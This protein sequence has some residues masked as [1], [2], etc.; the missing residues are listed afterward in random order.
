M[1]SWIRKL[2][3]ADKPF[4]RWTPGEKDEAQRHLA[5]V[6]K[7]KHSSDD[8]ALCA[9]LLI[10]AFQPADEKRTEGEQQKV[11]ASIRHKAADAIANPRTGPA[12]WEVISKRNEAVRAALKI[13][14]WGKRLAAL[15]DVGI[16]HVRIMAGNRTCSRCKAMENRKI[17]IDDLIDADGRN[18]HRCRDIYMHAIDPPAPDDDPVFQAWLDKNLHR[19][20]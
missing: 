11:L 10:Q 15:K 17:P 5:T 3:G 13:P 4:R 19:Y 6:R 14:Q 2:F 20:E 1:A 16:I 12:A 9:E 7:D 18:Q 8:V